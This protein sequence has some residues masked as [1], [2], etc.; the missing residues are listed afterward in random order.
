MASPEEKLNAYIAAVEKGLEP[1]MQAAIDSFK[2][3]TFK[4]GPKHRRP[5]TAIESQGASFMAERGYL[6]FPSMKRGS[7][8]ENWARSKEQMALLQSVWVTLGDFS[9]F[10]QHARQDFEAEILLVSKSVGSSLDDAD[11]VVESFDEPQRYLVP[12]LAVRRDPIPVLLDHPSKLLE[13]LQSL[14]PQGPGPAHTFPLMEKTL[15]NQAETQE[16][17]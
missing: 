2:D 1:R 11:L 8:D 5:P 13:R 10:W 9:D 14:P 6:N 16:R 7:T 4:D 12:L 15:R 17:L 3:Q